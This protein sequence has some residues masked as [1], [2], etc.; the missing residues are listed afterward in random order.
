M[1]GKAFFA[2]ALV[3]LIPI[4]V[5]AQAKEFD[6][7]KADTSDRMTYHRAIDAAVWAM[8]LMN[9]KFY[10]DALID[11][12]VGP[13]D[14]GYYSKVQDWKFQTATPNNTTPYVLAHWTIKD[15]PIVVEIPAA[16]AD[17]GIF[18]TLMD[19]W[20]RPIDDVGAAGRDKGMG[21][22]YLL[23]PEG[24]TGP[25]L[26]NARVY[27]QRTDNGFAI[28]RPIIADSSPENLAMAAEYVKK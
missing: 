26:P 19:A 6:L 24:Y 23:L 7:Q 15:G 3:V 5:L 9:Y 4:T 21:A 2:L 27:R 13:N 22:K 20:Q 8:P 1:N 25:T 10:R 12:G 28:L 17:V 14:I 16:T 11:A 18:G